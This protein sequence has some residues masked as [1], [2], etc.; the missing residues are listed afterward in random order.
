MT[1]FTQSLHLRHLQLNGAMFSVLGGTHHHG[2]FSTAID[3]H[4]IQYNDESAQSAITRETDRC[5]LVGKLS[6]V[7]ITAKFIFTLLLFLGHFKVF[8]NSSNHDNIFHI[9][10]EYQVLYLSLASTFFMFLPCNFSCYGTVWRIE[11]RNNLNFVV[12]NA[13][14]LSMNNSCK[15]LGVVTEGTTTQDRVCVTSTTIKAPSGLTSS[16][17]TSHSAE[18]RIPYSSSTATEDITKVEHLHTTLDSATSVVPN[19]TLDELSSTPLTAYPGLPV[20]SAIITALTTNR[21]VTHRTPRT[22]NSRYVTTG[23]K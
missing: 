8:E 7:V 21:R 18:P 15:G 17:S 20:S 16:H 14:Y 10:L 11:R 4:C 22:L 19:I 6:L 23:N 1:L 13:S 5:W 12:I 3:L 9:C 2:R